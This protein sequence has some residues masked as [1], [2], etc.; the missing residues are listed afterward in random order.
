M[1]AGSACSSNPEEQLGQPR[2]SCSPVFADI[3]YTPSEDPKGTGADDKAAF[4]L[5]PT[6]AANAIREKARELST[7]VSP[8]KSAE[9]RQ[10]GLDDSGLLEHFLE[11]RLSRFLVG[12][13]KARMERFEEKEPRLQETYNIERAALNTDPRNRALSIYAQRGAELDEWDQLRKLAIFEAQNQ[14]YTHRDGLFFTAEAE[15]ARKAV[16]AYNEARAKLIDQYGSLS[17][18]LGMVGEVLRELKSRY[19]E[20]T[21]CTAE[22]RECRGEL[23]GVLLWMDE[24]K[25]L[26]NYVGLISQAA[27]YGLAL[28][29]FALIDTEGDVAS[30]IARFKQYIAALDAQRKVEAELREKYQRWVISS[31]QNIMPPAGLLDA[32]RARWDALQAQ[33]QQLQQQ[34]IAQVARD[35]VRRHLLWNPEAFVPQPVDRLVK[36]DFPLREV[37][38]PFSPDAPMHHLSL[39]MLK[40]LKKMPGNSDG[41]AA[42]DHATSDFHDW[43]LS[44]GALRIAAQGEWFDKE[45]WFDGEAF[46]Q[47]LQAHRYQVKSLSTAKARQDWS[48]QLRQMLFKSD[49]QQRLRM[50][51]NSPSAALVRFLTPPQKDLHT[52]AKFKGKLF[53]LTGELSADINLARGEVEV[54]KIDLP[55]RSQAPEVKVPYQVEGDS[56]SHQINIGKFSVHMSLR[57]WGFAGASVLVSGGLKVGIGNA[58]YGASLDPIQP[59]VRKDGTASYAKTGSTPPLF[60]GRAGKAKI[61]D[62]VKASFNLFAGLQAGINVT[63]ALNWAPP[64][65]LVSP[66][67]VPNMPG[68]PIPDGGW[69]S[70]SRLEG[71]V[72]AAIGAGARGDVGLSLSK[73]CLILRIKAAL[74]AGPG[75]QGSL[76]FAVGYEAIVD[77]LDL[78]RRELHNNQQRDMRWITPPAM[79]LLA[80]LNFA[81]SLGLDVA[82]LYLLNSAEE[83][84]ML[85]LRIADAV[86]SVY[87]AVTGGGKGGPIAY[88]ILN[89]ENQAELERWFVECIP[90]ALG[91]MLMTLISTPKAFEIVDHIDSPLGGE[92]RKRSYS[93]GESHLFQ[94]QAIEQVLRWIVNNAKADPERIANAQ[95]QFDSACSRM[96]KFGSY[97]H[98]GQ[99]YCDSRH[100]MDNFMRAVPEAEGANLPGNM[101]I[102]SRYVGHVK[103]LGALR[104]NFCQSS[105]FYGKTYIPGGRSVYIGPGV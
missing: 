37:S 23:I 83:K 31:G 24:R 95:R 9:E 90:A 1:Q 27:N 18:A 40:G 6:P 57:A 101:A 56:T 45:G 26:F 69:L 98:K 63:G 72:A 66:T 103:T 86:M 20:A 48:D 52:G 29:E 74:I 43:L 17:K 49:A 47:Y 55:E 44:Q 99:C 42:K 22:L 104:D 59:A 38:W 65:T 81:G 94:Q 97:D 10:R 7:L 77:L 68:Q 4:W 13:Q 91:P 70:L 71:G 36:T 14:G 28:P 78:L 25:T 87:E 75:L 58:G 73:G 21:R 46:H 2:L 61:E 35:K 30:G 12:D 93:R 50:F 8:T 82:L 16:Q 3:I 54:F 100:K 39:D 51:D 19:D 60:E 105:D 15:S 84:A 11:P 64:P 88:A 32:E 41:K 76:S 34:A 96:N 102:R 89:Y 67:R 33:M 85:G 62:G 53:S 92:E 80:H 79:E 5:L